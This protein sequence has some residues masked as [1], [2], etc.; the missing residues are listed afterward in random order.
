MDRDL[1]NFYGVET[2]SLNQAVKRN[3]ERFPV[4]YRFQLTKGETEEV[5]TKCDHLSGL[6]YSPTYYRTVKLERKRKINE[7]RVFLHY[8]QA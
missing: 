7:K 4:Y 2:K 5:V 8:E 6:K 3:M 1:A